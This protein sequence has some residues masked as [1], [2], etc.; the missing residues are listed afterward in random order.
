MVLKKVI[1][2]RFDFCFL[3]R[4]E[5]VDETFEKEFSDVVVRRKLLDRRRIVSEG[6][7]VNDC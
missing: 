2:L 7:C 3:L 1:R 5:L 4:I 6:D